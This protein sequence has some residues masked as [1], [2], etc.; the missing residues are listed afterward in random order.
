MSRFREGAREA[1]EADAIEVGTMTVL[2]LRRAF[3]VLAYERGERMAA[4]AETDA[5]IY[6]IRRELEIRAQHPETLGGV[7]L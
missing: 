1:A 3:S 4:L 5:Q 2:E 6:L 7:R